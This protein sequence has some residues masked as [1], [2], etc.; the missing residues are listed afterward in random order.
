[1]SGNFSDDRAI[2]VFRSRPLRIFWRLVL[3][4][5]VGVVALPSTGHALAGCEI[6]SGVSDLDGFDLEAEFCDEPGLPPPVPSPFNVPSSDSDGN[7]AISWGASSGATR[8]MLY[9]SPNDS[10][11]SVIYNGSSRSR[12]ITGKTSGRWYYRVRACNAS[13]DCSYY[14]Q[15]KSVYVSISTPTPPPTPSSI[16]GPSTDTDGTFTLS[17][18]Y[19]S[20]ATTYQLQRQ[21]DG[22]GF[23]TIQNTSARSRNETGLNNSTYG[24]RVRACNSAGCSGFTTT[25]NVVVDKPPEFPPPPPPPPA[26]PPAPNSGDVIGRTVGLADVSATGEGTYSIPISTPPGIN[27]LQPEIALTYGHRR[28]EGIAGV[29]WNVSGLSAISRC[30]KTTAQNGSPSGVNLARSDRYCLDGNQLKHVSGTYGYSGSRY[31]TEVDMIARVTA[32]GSAGNGPAWFKVES[33][34]GLVYEYGNSS[35]S[36]IESLALGLESTARTWAL[37]KVRDRAGNEMRYYYTE[38]GAPF[39]AYRISTIRYQLNPSAGASSIGHAVRF[40]YQSQPANDVDTKYESGGLVEDRQRLTSIVVQQSG[41]YYSPIVRRYTLSYESY[42]SSANRSR[43]LSVQECGGIVQTCLPPTTFTYQNGSNSLNGETNSWATIPSGTDPLTIDINGDGR[44]DVVYPSSASSGVWMYRLGNA[45]GGYNGAV[46]TGISS[47]N[48]QYA[49]AIEYDQDGIDDILVPFDGNAWYVM[50]GSTSG[51]RAP[52]SVGVPRESRAGNAAALD[53][54]GDG[55]DDLVY[56]ASIYGPGV[57]QLRVRYRQGA[58]FSSTPSVLYTASSDAIIGG[59]DLF[60]SADTRARSMRIDFNG[61]GYRDIP[62]VVGHEEWRSGEPLEFFD[63]YALLGAGRGTWHISGNKKLPLPVDINGDGYTDIAY[64]FTNRVYTRLSTGKGFAPS[65]NTTV[66]NIDFSKAVALDWDSDGFQDVVVPAGS[67]YYVVPSKGTFLGNAFNTYIATGNPRDTLRLDV[68]G[69]GLGD[70]A[71]VKSDGRFAHRRHAGLYPDL[72]KSVTDGNGN[73]TRYFYVPLSNSAFYTRRYDASLPAQDYIGPIQIVRMMEHSTGIGGTYTVDYRYEGATADLT[74]RGLNGFHKRTAIDNRNGNKVIETYELDFPYRSRLDRREL[75]T[76]ANT[77]IYELDSNWNH[78]LR[79]SGNERYYYPYLSSSIERN[80]EATGTYRGNQINEVVKSYGVDTYGTVTNTVVMTTENTAANGLQPGARYYEQTLLQSVTNNT[81]YWCLGKPGRIEQRN[82]HSRT[83]G[84]LIVRTTDYSWNTGSSCRLNQLVVEPGSTSYR[85]TIGLGYDAFGNVNSRTVTGINMASR[86]TSWNYGTTGQFLQSETNALSQTTTYGWDARTGDLL[87]ITDPNQLRT[88]WRYDNFGRRIQELRSDTTYTDYSFMKCTSAN[89]YCGSSYSQAKARVRATTKSPTGSIV[90]YADTYLDGLD[91][92]IQSSSQSLN[93]GMVHQ[94]ITFDA[95]GRV[96]KRYRPAFS[97]TPSKSEDISYDVIGRVY[98]VSVPVNDATSARKYTTLTYEG[99]TVRTQDAEGSTS[100]KVSDALGRVYRSIDDAGYY[101]QFDYDGFGNLRRLV[102]STGAVLTSNTYSYGIDAF[103]RNVNDMN[104]GSWNY[105]P[106]ALG[107][108]VSYRDAKGRN[109]TATFDK[110]GRPLTRVEA[111]GTTR[112]TWGASSSAKN[113]GQLQ[114]VSSPGYEE[115]YLY[116]RYGRLTRTTTTT[117][118]TYFTDYTYDVA[119]GQPAETWYP[120]S[121]NNYRFRVRNEYQYGLL[122]RVRKADGGQYIYWQANSTDA[123]GFVIDETMYNNVRTIRSYDGVTGQLD[124]IQS[125]LNGGSAMQNMTYEWDRVGNL[126]RRRDGNRSLD[127]RFYY[128]G[129]HRFDYSTLNGSVNLDLAYS[130]NGNIRRKSDVASTDWVYHSTKKNAVVNAGGTAYG[131]DANGNMTT[132]AG[133]SITWTSYN[134]PS[135]I[136][137]GS[138]RYEYSYGPD[139]QKWK[140]VFVN[141]LPETTIYIGNNYEKNISNSD[142]EHR[143]YVR[144]NGR[145]VAMYTRRQ[146]GSDYHRY[147][148]SDH[149]GSIAAITTPGG[150][151]EVAQ[152]FTAFGERR[153]PR[154]WSGAP[155]SG[156]LSMIGARSDMGYTGHQNLE[157]SS[158]IHMKGRVFDAKIGRSLS[159]DPYVPNPMNTQSFNRYSYV[160]NNPMRYVDPDGFEGICVEWLSCTASVIAT[161]FAFFGGG[162]DKPPPPNYEELVGPIARGEVAQQNMQFADDL[163]QLPSASVQDVTFTVSISARPP[164]LLDRINPFSSYNVMQHGKQLLRYCE[165]TCDFGAIDPATAG[166]FSEMTANVGA[167]GV[168][169]LSV[170][171]RASTVAG[172]RRLA[173]ATRAGTAAAGVVDDA[174]AIIASV[175]QQQVQ[176]GTQHLLGQ[177]SAAERAAFLANPAGGSRFIGTAVHKATAR[178]LENAYPGRFN[179]HPTRSF[180]FIDLS[181]GQAIE[182]TTVRG[183]AS[184]ANRSANIVTYSW[185]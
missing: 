143:H 91:R 163:S 155:P 103:R 156:D 138:K 171:G 102:D 18:G 184:H 149:Q 137:E 37:S 81:T 86:T 131:Y 38:D 11:W 66:Y 52:V 77:L 25:K 70:L 168:G 180:D 90:R 158:L 78:H 79:G 20:G 127:E 176:R 181:T 142:V 72:L 140:Q 164:S 36:R 45:S 63:T 39:G 119:T 6:R 34:D 95:L 161:A 15:T 55:K 41:P 62:F 88:S 100:V 179:Y 169:Q 92:G 30:R 108:N 61:D 111:E 48:H 10:T 49:I 120:V 31:R 84:G 13:L 139:R 132:R 32:Y 3:A 83:Y 71:Y 134:Y 121:T 148:L 67:Y 8:Y 173:T 151:I 1:M 126:T 185:P 74:G 2:I 159:A 24:Y 43:L 29:G 166:M 165:P 136:R 105:Y 68:D 17:W 106:N 174:E 153:D 47:V 87:S 141:G 59:G 33:K 75:R 12:N 53:M 97:P 16:S 175:A 154:D 64:G 125:G 73:L 27:G 177:L 14:T 57:N 144:A 94:R 113:V 152:S 124:Y 99:L 162:D 157:R 26:A 54:N 129:L 28:S 130:A 183:V 114:F 147:I 115:S 182:L 58:G 178:A 116:D 22:S 7:Y 167:V 133:S 9:E 21:A 23:A 172:S 110:L 4:G 42:L 35:D 76:S 40:Y 117:D 128:D 145:A 160:Y 82:S 19:S 146:S 109:F 56:G 65:T 170:A 98:Q 104:L 122:K 80:Y 96:A 60:R 107:E 5:L 101:Q 93:G 135:V 123:L 50:K 69:D 112:W 51:L 89:S 46:N 85:A 44:I 118:D 150:A